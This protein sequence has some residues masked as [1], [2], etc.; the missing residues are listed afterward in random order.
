MKNR[1]NTA[2]DRLCAITTSLFAQYGSRPAAFQ[3]ACKLHPDLAAEAVD[4]TGKR[5]LQG[6]NPET[7]AVQSVQAGEA[8][9][10]ALPWGEV[11]RSIGAIKGGKADVPELPE[12]RG[13][14][15][16]ALPWSEVM[17][18]IQTEGRA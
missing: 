16:K 1:N 15:G 17:R 12:V 10:Q 11:L 8:A 6:S 14:Q 2:W 13:E 4:P 7:A 18:K 5:L 9:G 3:A